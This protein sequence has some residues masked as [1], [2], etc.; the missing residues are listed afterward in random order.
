M[1]KEYD[2]SKGKRGRFFQEDVAFHVAVYPDEA[3][4]ASVVN[5]LIRTDREIVGVVE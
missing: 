3:N 5:E 1:K 4:R 2:L